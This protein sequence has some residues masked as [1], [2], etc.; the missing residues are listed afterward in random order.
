[1]FDSAHIWHPYTSFTR[2][3]PVY[4]VQRAEGCTLVLEDGRKLVDGMASWW[5]AI[6]GYNHPVLN[7]AVTKQLKQMA[8]VMFGGLTH[9]PAV[10]L[11]RR[12]IDI[13]PPGLDTVFLCD[14]G[15]VSVEVAIKMAIQYWSAM[16]RPEKQRLA[17]IRSGYHGD[18]LGA[19]SVCDP[20]TGM[21]HIFSGILPAQL[22]ADAPRSPFGGPLDEADIQSLARL[23]EDH[24]RE[25][26]AL[27]LEPVV[28]GAGGMRFYSPDYLAR[29]RQLCDQYEVLLICDEIATG[30]G[31]TGKLFACE[32]AGLSPDIMCVGKALTGGYMTLA[33]T[34]ASEKVAHGISSGE[35]GL[36]MHGPT[37]MGNPLA[38]ATA[39]AAI[40]LLQFFDWQKTVAAME[41][42][43]KREL[44]PC[45]DMPHVQEVRCLGG[46][47]VVETKDTVDTAWAQ[48]RF[49]ER[50]VWVRPFGRLVYIMPPY[51]ITTD[52]LSRLT[53]AICE[54]VGLAGLASGAPS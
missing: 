21:H 35:P 2:P 26:A 54:V 19:M 12:L 24:H 18:T 20:V 3:L 39:V 43:M 38:C 33:A 4:P 28:Q 32:H 40:D 9:A 10:E 8:H 51:I 16:G 14:S 31:R 44:A 23:L 46:I 30:F 49:V 1:M 34:L 7:Q 53:S 27:I 45:A 15:S 6:F 29:A 41:T 48:A 5:T 17:T 22:F 36:F 50:G 37:F 42:Q 47:G 25:V 13:S 11:C 52:E